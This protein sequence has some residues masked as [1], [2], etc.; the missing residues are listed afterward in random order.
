MPILKNQAK[1]EKFY[2]ETKSSEA[3]ITKLPTHSNLKFPLNKKP[4]KFSRHV[5]NLIA[6]LRGVPEDYSPIQ[7]KEAKTVDTYLDKIINKY[8]LGEHTLQDLLVEKWVEI[9]GEGNA[10]NCG[11]V[12]IEKENTLIIAVSSPII[13]QELQFNKAII[14]KNIQS[15]KGAYK[16]RYLIFKTG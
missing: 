11:P 8:N 9:V 2:L 14:L 12:R 1:K 7:W 15:L 13:R 3:S 4:Y 5:E 6:N 10:R 16:I